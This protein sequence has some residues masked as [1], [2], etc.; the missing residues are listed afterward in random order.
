MNLWTDTI[1]K[2]GQLLFHKKIEPYK[3]LIDWTTSTS[4]I[5]TSAILFMYDSY[6][7]M[8]LKYSCDLSSGKP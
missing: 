3:Y 7:Y 8:A 6:T 4:V 2:S 1:M 5:S